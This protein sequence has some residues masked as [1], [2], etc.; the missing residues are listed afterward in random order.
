MG[1]GTSKNAGTHYQHGP[2]GIKVHATVSKQFSVNANKEMLI[3]L[4]Q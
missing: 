3:P 2:N 4:G 1:G